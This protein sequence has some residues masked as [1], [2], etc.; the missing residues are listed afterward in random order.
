MNYQ[1]WHVR[2]LSNRDIFGTVDLVDALR[3]HHMHY[4]STSLMRT[5]LTL[6]SLCLLWLMSIYRSIKVRECRGEHDYIS[7]HELIHLN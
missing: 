3:S 5:E 1:Q 6:K 2:L 7:Q 4:S